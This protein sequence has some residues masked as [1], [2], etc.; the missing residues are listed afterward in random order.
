M[1]VKV[2][3]DRWKP[4][5]ATAK[6]EGKTLN[7]YARSRGLAVC[8]LYAARQ[9]LQGIGEAGA[10][11]AGPARASAGFGVCVGEACGAGDVVGWVDGAAAGAPAQ[12][13]DAG[14]GGSRRGIAR[15]GDQDAGEAAIFRFNGNWEVYVH[16]EA[17]DFKTKDG[18]DLGS[19]PP[20][21][22]Q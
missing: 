9:M 14:I 6:R 21:D 18:R 19:H 3:L 4:H 16:R 13:R 5:L 15:G 7:A 22:L 12:R 2:N 20:L 17:V 8:T 10:R 1:S 11:S